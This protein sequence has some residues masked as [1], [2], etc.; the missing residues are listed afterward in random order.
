MGVGRSDGMKI[1]RVEDW[2][3]RVVRGDWDRVGWVWLGLV[4]NVKVGWVG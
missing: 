2:F 4:G 1:G 3:G